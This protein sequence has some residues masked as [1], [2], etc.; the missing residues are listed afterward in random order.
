MEGETVNVTCYSGRHY[1]DRPV[2]FIWRGKRHEVRQ[3]DK[4]WLEPG[5]RSFTVRTTDE[6]TFI[7]SYHRR[8]DRWSLLEIEA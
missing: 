7:I 6:K 1:D 8:E 5:E 4:E 3:I 2:S